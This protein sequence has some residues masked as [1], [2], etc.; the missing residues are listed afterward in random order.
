VYLLFAL[1]SLELEQAVSDAK[2]LMAIVV[3]VTAPQKK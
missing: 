3:S 1:D 2:G